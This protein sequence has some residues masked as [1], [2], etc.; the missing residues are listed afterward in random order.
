V[1]SARSKG[2]T[3]KGEA[4]AA[5]QPEAPRRKL[6]GVALGELRVAMHKLGQATQELNEIRDTILDAH[7]A[8]RDQLDWSTGLIY[9][10]QADASNERQRIG[11]ITT[12]EDRKQRAA[13]AAVRTRDLAVTDLRT[14]F[15]D[16]LGCM[17][18]DI[19][20]QSGEVTGGPIEGV[21]PYAP[22]QQAGT[23]PESPASSDVADAAPAEHPALEPV[24]E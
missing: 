21:D 5:E 9:D 19:D 3:R 14:R 24:G 20:P 15:A 23:T 13:I 17:P 18:S 10:A 7:H 16:R 22:A 2:E 4:E 1:V 11:R 12:D 8:F 6:Q